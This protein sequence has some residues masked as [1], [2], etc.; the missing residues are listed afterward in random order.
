MVVFVGVKDGMIH[1]YEVKN[2]P[3]A[4]F[5]KNQKIAIPKLIEQHLPITPY[6][7]NASNVPAFK[8]LIID[9]KPYT[10][11]YKVVIKHYW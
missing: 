8:S 5:T 7:R 11:N 10:G 4:K 3:Y 6:G 9:N 2:G 1:I